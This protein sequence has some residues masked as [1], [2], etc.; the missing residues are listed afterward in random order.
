MIGPLA[1]APCTFFQGFYVSQAHVMLHDES[2]RYSY[3]WQIL[4][5]WQRILGHVLKYLECC[6]PCCA[7][8]TGG[9]V[10]VL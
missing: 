6:A 1:T 2:K 4:G 9:V 3:P 5:M 8:R 10:H 7:P